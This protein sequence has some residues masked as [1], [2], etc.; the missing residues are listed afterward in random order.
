M[1]I[2]SIRDSKAEI[3]NTPF[4]SRNA[5]TAIRD[6]TAGVNDPN[7]GLG[8]NTADYDLF[9]IGGWDEES[10]RIVALD[11]PKHL[12]NGIDVRKEQN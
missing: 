10:G 1:K 8:R 2:Y 4:Y 5:Q 3:Y 6:F 12:V 11:A 7:S 9:E